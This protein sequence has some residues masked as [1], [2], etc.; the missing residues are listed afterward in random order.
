VPLRKPR[1][2]A[3]R[4]AS[5]LWV[6]VWTGENGERRYAI[7]HFDGEWA[8]PDLEYVAYPEVINQFG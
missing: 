2:V 3:R 4:I 7:R 8:T 5:P 1:G 6:F